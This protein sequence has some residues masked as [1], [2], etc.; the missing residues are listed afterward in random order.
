MAQSMQAVLDDAFEKR[1]AGQARQLAPVAK[2]VADQK[3][4]GSHAVQPP[5]ELT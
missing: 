1:P 4:P 2:A 5:V 3:F